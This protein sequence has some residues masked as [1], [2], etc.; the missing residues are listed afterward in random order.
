MPDHRPAAPYPMPFT[1][2]ELAVL[3]VREGR[4]QALLAL[5]KARPHAGQWALPGGVVRIDLDDTL[6]QAVQR[7]A[8]ERLQVTP[9]HMRQVCTV[10]G[11]ARDA[12]APWA[13]SVVYRALLP[14]A[15]G[16]A[17][18]PG[19]RIESLAW[20]PVDDAMDD[21]TLAFDHAALLTRAVDATR[22]EVA[23]LDLPPGFMPPAFTLG[24]LQARCEQVLGRPLDKSSFRRRLA[25]RE[26]VQPLA[27]ELRTGAFRP[28]QLYGLLP[29][30]P[31]A[32]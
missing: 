13:L 29:G 2:V 6:E 22:D 9:P 8:L 23:R 4:L 25:A 12:R 10:G 11:A 24:D 15:D 21:R 19:K 31:T 18:T 1:R 5:R 3:A 14:Q 20:R 26:L 27:G 17:P 7:I 32:G 16:L 28:A 30:V